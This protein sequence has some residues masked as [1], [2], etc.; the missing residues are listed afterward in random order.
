VLS[1]TGMEPCEAV[2]GHKFAQATTGCAS[3]AVGARNNALPMGIVKSNLAISLDGIS[4]APGQSSDEPFGVGVDRLTEWMFETDLPGREAD[5]EPDTKPAY[6][7]AFGLS[8]SCGLRRPDH[9]AE[10]VRSAACP[11]SPRS[12]PPP[13][14]LR[15]ARRR[16]PEPRRCPGSRRSPSAASGG[17]SAAVRALPRRP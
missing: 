3:K 5:A 11:R 1:P 6:G 7:S 13:P 17:S 8:A 2:L 15:P 12:S 14:P 16:R 10:R 9:R 4:S